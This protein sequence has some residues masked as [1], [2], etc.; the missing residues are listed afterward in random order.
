MVASLPPPP[1][2]PSP[3]GSTPPFRPQFVRSLL[4]APR[5][6][7]ILGVAYV[8]TVGTF[9]GVG[10]ADPFIK[11]P[12]LLAAGLTL[13]IGV[14]GIIA[15]YGIT[16]FAQPLHLFHAG[17]SMEVCSANG[18]CHG[19]DGMRGLWLGVVVGVLYAVLATLNF[20]VGVLVLRRSRVPTTCVL[21]TALDRGSVES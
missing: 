5:W 8:A 13:P 17:T 19:T 20:S 7:Q 16:A 10:A 18:N 2:P 3:P 21:V 12:L 6:V 14:L 15:F 1:Q 11:W 4:T 9:A